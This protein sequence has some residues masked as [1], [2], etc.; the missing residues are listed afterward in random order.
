M[1]EGNEYW[2]VG[3][4][5]RFKG[6]GVTPLWE[7]PPYPLSYPLPVHNLLLEAK[8]GLILGDSLYS[9]KVFV[10]GCIGWVDKVNMYRI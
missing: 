10:D 7:E 4:M 5:V 8:L 6:K 3:K 2:M 1:G 9:C